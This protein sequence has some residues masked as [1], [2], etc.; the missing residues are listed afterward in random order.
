MQGSDTKGQGRNQHPQNTIN[1]PQITGK[2]LP[3]C[4]N[5]VSEQ[6]H[7]MCSINEQQATS[8]AQLG[9]PFCAQLP[10]RQEA[11]LPIY[12]ECFPALHMSTPAITGVS[13]T[14]G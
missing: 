13:H 12:N 8:F 2:A 11:N 7:I 5:V 6:P 1:K 10:S 14:T 3:S 4:V 9:P